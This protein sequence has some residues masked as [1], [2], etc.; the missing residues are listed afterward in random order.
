MSFRQRLSLT[1]Q[2]SWPAIMAQLS[3]ILMQYIDAAMVGRLGADDSAA[4]GLVSTSLWL[5][6]G[7][8]SSAMVGFS[9]QVAHRMGAADY[10]GARSV[11]R[12]GLGSAVLFGFV[13]A[14]IGCAIAV[15]LPHWLGGDGKVC[16][17][18][19]VY[20]M[21]FVASLPLLTLNYLGGGVLRASGNM[22]VAGA[23]NVLMCLLDVVFNFFFIFPSREMQLAGAS[24][25][26][27]GLGL[28]VLGA[29]L[30]TVC[31]EIVSAALMLWYACVRQPD[32]AIVGR[33]A[34]GR[35]IL[36]YTCHRDWRDFLPTGTVLRNA[37]RVSAPMTLEHGVI[38]GAQI[39]V[40][41]IVAPLGVMAIA[42][43]AFA[44]TAE[45][46]C[47]MPGYGIGDAATTLVGQSYGAKRKDLAR[48]FGYLTVGLGMAVM[49]VMGVILWLAAP[50]VMEL[51]SPVADIQSLGVSAL[52]I[53]A[54]AEPM[55]AA[56]IVAYGVMVGVGDTIVPA[57]MNFS[58][59]WLVRLP[60]A[61]L[62]AP[63][64]GL[65]G[66]W[67]AMCIELCFRG[68]IFLWRLVSGA[69]LRKGLKTDTAV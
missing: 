31:A 12:Q 69:W 52:R 20:F 37:L 43:N 66:V 5:F 30:G 61:A 59:I 23:V 32:L 54:W 67:L 49:T 62:L 47:Y 53:E 9:V 40:T 41:V 34:A 57:A 21:V 25:H 51:L 7:L 33:R 63:S 35:D 45:A 22:K 48:Q 65:D 15:P 11:L 50:A 38:C 44:V 24:L 55:F 13:M 68:L 36:P 6:W 28:G 58:S 1:A 56:S 39:V 3:S 10:S 29:A 27:P 16:E 18:A 60:I 4:V 64:M 14:V 42:A 17:G 19:S 8:C 26:I 2:L 46:L